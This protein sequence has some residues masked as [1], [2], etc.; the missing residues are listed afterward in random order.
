MTT[1]N[2]TDAK[3]CR[4][5]LPNT[6]RLAQ[7]RPLAEYGFALTRTNDVSGAGIL[8][9]NSDSKSTFV[10]SCDNLSWLHSSNFDCAFAYPLPSNITHEPPA[11][12]APPLLFLL[13][14]RCDF[15]RSAP[16]VG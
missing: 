2:G 5:T 3:S 15:G 8:L 9:T 10:S 6:N 4:T 13:Q 16:C 1:E 12:M 14:G 11:E 7:L